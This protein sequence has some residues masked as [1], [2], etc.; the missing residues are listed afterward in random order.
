MR[1]KPD[2]V[3]AVDEALKELGFEQKDTP[4]V[5]TASIEP[6]AERAVRKS[7]SKRKG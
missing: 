3:K 2:R 4:E 7:A 1:K 5:E 6:Q